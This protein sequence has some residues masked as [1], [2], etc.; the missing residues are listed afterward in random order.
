MSIETIDTRRY[1]MDAEVAAR[2]W[3]S[4]FDKD[5]SWWA[6][7]RPVAYLVFAAAYIV[8]NIV[9][10]HQKLLWD[11][12]FFTLYL[13]RTASWSELW[14]ALSTGADQHPPSFYYLT[15]FILKVFGTT[16]V[17]LRSTALF[18]FA[19]S[20]VC[21]YEIAREMAGRR[22][23]LPAMLLPL[24]TPAL[25]YATEAR[26]YG[27]ELGFTTFSLLMWTWATDGKKR[28]WTV[29]ALALGLCL[30]EASHYY[31]LFILLPL[32]LGELA[33]IRMR[34]SVDF[35]ICGA[36]FAAMLPT[37]FFAPLI[38]DVLPY[39][40]TFWALPAWSQ[41]LYWY[42]SMLGRAPLILLAAAALVFVFK[43]PTTE[44]LHPPI[45]RPSQPVAV[46]LTMTA[47]LPVAG[48]IAAKFVTHAF[49]ERYF[50]AALPAAIM[51]LIWALLRVIRNDRVGPALTTALCLVLFAHQ[52]RDLQSD[53]ITALRTMRSIA[54][55]L[56]RN[57]D[58]PIVV[59]DVTNF[60]RL[61][62]YAQRDL[63]RR[64]AYAA[65]PH[66]SVRYLG[67]DTIDRGMLALDAWFPLRTVWWDEWWRTHPTS[68]VYGGVGEWNWITFALPEIGT[69]ELKDR[70]TSHLLLIVNRSMIPGNDHLLGDPPGKPMLYDELP[71]GGPTL[72]KVYMPTDECPV[73]DDPSFSSPIIS[74]P[75]L[76]IRK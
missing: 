33:K 22:W 73:I 19:L 76:R 29:P 40:K 15:H 69:A 35:P 48:M 56:R 13:S 39:S 52:W 49:T 65:D 41:I 47:V 30:A 54:T 70:D 24:T 57:P 50:I 21:L 37:L 51:L 10:A 42:P 43:I 46:G 7:S 61:S 17:S 71:A 6:E 31:A 38:V 67:Q 23:G 27:L 68:L 12:E 60:H 74:Y 63:A 64:L 11:D 3:R 59:S 9:L 34:R 66:L 62:F 75:D 14:R 2:P 53:Q 8:P 20:C 58:I 55:L 45:A 72:C 44:D 18:G 16:H 25:Y 5:W 36:L 26:G 4:R 32:A 28:A 1:D